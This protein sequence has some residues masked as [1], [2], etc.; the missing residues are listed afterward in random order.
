MEPV[1][2]NRAEVCCPKADPPQERK[3]CSL[4]SRDEWKCVAKEICIDEMLEGDNVSNFVRE[5]QAA[6]CEQPNQKCCNKV[7]KPPKKEPIETCSDKKGYQCLPLQ[8][9]DT[10]TIISKESPQ[11]E[12]SLDI[13]QAMIEINHEL[14]Y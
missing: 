11:N 2:S 5:A 14:R 7:F 8:S 12:F 1:C 13:R 6:T 9:C 3:K 10:E 4:F